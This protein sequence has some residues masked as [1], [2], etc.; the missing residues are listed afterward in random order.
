MMYSL[1]LV[2]VIYMYLCKLL[3]KDVNLFI[4]ISYTF[5]VVNFIVVEGFR[6]Y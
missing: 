1:V 3:I 6:S 4:K 5:N 2:H